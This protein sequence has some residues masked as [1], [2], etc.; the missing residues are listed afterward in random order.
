[1]KWHRR[2]RSG[3]RKSPFK[4][5]LVNDLSA[6][7]HLSERDWSALIFVTH[8]GMSQ[9]AFLEI[10]TRW[11][12]TAKHPRFKRLYVELVYQPMSEVLGYLRANRFATYIVTGFGQDFVRGYSQR[13]LWHPGAVRG[14]KPRARRCSMNE[15][16]ATEWRK[17]AAV[18]VAAIA[19]RA[20]F[21]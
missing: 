19:T 6:L 4:A 7:A 10:A 20:D 11:L 15:G 17:S 18:T 12:T 14:A 5:V 1:M 3:S 21:P 2:I 8:A 13:V 9:T 16:Q